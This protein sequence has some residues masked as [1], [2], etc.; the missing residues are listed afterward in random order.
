MGRS[1]GDDR[2][3]EHSKTTR[4]RWLASLAAA[5]VGGLAGCNFLDGDGTTPA[6]EPSPSSTSPATPTPT[7]TQTPTLTST[8]TPTDRTIEFDGGGATAFAAALDELRGTTGGTLRIAAGTHRFDA[9]EAPT[10]E[11]PRDDD[12]VHFDGTGLDGTTITGPEGDG[13][14]EIVLEDP[15]RGFILFKN[16]AGATAADR[17]RGPTVRNLLVRHDPLPYTQGRIEALS[18]DRRTVTLAL[19]PGFVPLDDPPFTAEQTRVSASVFRSDGRRIRRVS[20]EARSNFKRFGRIERVGDRRYRLT[21]AEGVEPGGLR[22]DRRLAVLPRV[23]NAT[24]FTHADLTNPTYEGV[25]VESTAKYAFE[26]NAC[27]RP[28]LRDCV[29][30]P[31]EAGLVSTNA[32]GIHCNNCPRGPLVEGSLLERT[33]DDAVVADNE[34]MAVREFLDDRTVRV[35]AGFGTRV[36]AGDRLVAASDRLERKGMLPAVEAVD[37]RGGGVTGDPVN[38]ESITFTEPVRDRLA[39]GDALTG[40]RMQNAETVVRDTTVRST[41]ARFVRLGG[42]AGSLVEDNTFVGTNSDGVEIAAAADI[43]PSFSD[44]KGWSTDVRIRGNEIT[45]VGLYGVPSG[46]PRAVFVGVDGGE[47]FAPAQSVTGQP[48]RNIR[49]EDNTIERTGGH[50]VEIAD[51]ESVTVTETTVTAPGLLRGPDIGQYGIGLRNVHTAGIER[52]RV[53]TDEQETPGY[54]WRIEVQGLTTADNEFAVADES[55]A[56]TV[57]H[58]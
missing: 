9:S 13:V 34:L 37:E 18:D 31:P 39:T 41:R 15:T 47:G 43:R 46:V 44:L 32:D 21:L 4:R 38:P 7:V 26:F 45:D 56:A 33:S 35:Y 27:E 20:D 40:A 25:T 55:R 57:E 22:V 30:A 12:R 54:G 16:A 14:A 36:G 5:S 6:E 58:L 50:G 11:Y 19:E 48:H 1:R 29:V 10:F 23:T 28:V 2:P 53:E 52:T 51:A 8:S 3:G 42:V 49:I 24:L 17:P